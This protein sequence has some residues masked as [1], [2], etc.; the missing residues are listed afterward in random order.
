M[1]HGIYLTLVRKDWRVF[2]APV[3]ATLLV[4]TVPYVID[5]L[6]SPVARGDLFTAA[7]RSS[8]NVAHVVGDSAMLAVVLTTLL[9]AAYGGAAFAAERRERSADFL[10]L[11]PANRLAIAAS[12]AFVALVCL[13]FAVAVHLA[14]WSWA[15][16]VMAFRGEHLFDT[17]TIAAVVATAAMLFGL[18]WCLS[19]ALTS[20]AISAMAAA[21]LAV[22]VSVGLGEAGALDGPNA[23]AVWN[24]VA[25]ITGTAAFIGGTICF[26]RRVAP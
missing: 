18:A 5:A 10:A 17:R 13:T 1:S 16:R 7:I 4:G 25:A 23:T 15:D 20:A 8:K 6:V 26:C 21:G 12:K 24:A 22:L 19:A 2:R 9:A 14:A 3:I 11:L